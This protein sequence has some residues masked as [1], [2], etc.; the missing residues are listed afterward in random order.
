[1]TELLLSTNNHISMRSE[2]SPLAQTKAFSLTA[3]DVAAVE[4][5]KT[6]EGAISDSAALRV[7]IRDGLKFRRLRHLAEQELMAR[8]MSEEDFHPSPHS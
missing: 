4:R 8:S 5:V 3:E 6:E 7:L 1:M 2:S